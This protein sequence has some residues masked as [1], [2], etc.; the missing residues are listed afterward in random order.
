[1]GDPLFPFH[2]V[3]AVCSSG[4]KA[5][6]GEKQAQAQKNKSEKCSLDSPP[7]NIS[8]AIHSRRLSSILSTLLVPSGL[9]IRLKLS[10]LESKG[11]GH[12]R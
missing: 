2:S 11:H 4:D 12:Y 3:T 9:F 6:R 8:P 10:P 7:S 1:M 5:T